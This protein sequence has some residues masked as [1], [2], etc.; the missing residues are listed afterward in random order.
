MPTEEYN[1]SDRSHQGFPQAVLALALMPPLMIMAPTVGVALLLWGM[2]FAYLSSLAWAD[3][4]SVNSLADD[5]DGTDGEC[6][7]REAII[8]ANTDGGGSR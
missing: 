8:A 3:T 7:L 5:A 4:I 6:T 1:S 2:L